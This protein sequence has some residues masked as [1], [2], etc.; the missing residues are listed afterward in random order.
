MLKYHTICFNKTNLSFGDSTPNLNPEDGRGYCYSEAINNFRLLIRKLF[1]KEIKVLL[2]LS[3]RFL[4]FFPCS[5][6][7]QPLLC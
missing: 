7:C 6:Q 2:V 1:V 5:D 3:F 4:A